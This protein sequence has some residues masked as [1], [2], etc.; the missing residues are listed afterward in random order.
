M[1]VEELNKDEEIQK[2]ADGYGVSV[3]E[4]K[5][6]MNEEMLDESVLRNHALHLLMDNAVRK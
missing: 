6:N 4:L 2:L 5:L 3:D 1:T